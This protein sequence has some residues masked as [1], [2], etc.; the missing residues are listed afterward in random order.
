MKELINSQCAK[1]NDKQ[2]WQ[3]KYYAYYAMQK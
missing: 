2:D 3:D 1:L